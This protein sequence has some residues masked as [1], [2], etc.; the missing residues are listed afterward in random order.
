MNNESHHYVWLYNTPIKIVGKK[1]EGEVKGNYSQK[2]GG[3]KQYDFRGKHWN[4]VAISQVMYL[5]EAEKDKE[6]ILP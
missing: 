1:E 4:D 6:Q 5:P 2:R 3:N